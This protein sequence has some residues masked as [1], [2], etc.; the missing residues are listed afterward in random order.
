MK[1]QKGIIRD[2]RATF[3]PVEL[4]DGA[5]VW[6]DGGPAVVNRPFFRLGD[7]YTVYAPTQEE[8][9]RTHYRGP[10]GG[11]VHLPARSVELV[12]DFRDDI[13]PLPLSGETRSPS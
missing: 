7:P 1:W 11:T 9:Y 3:G 8:L 2:T 5:E 10:D 6:V 4:L 12:A 13:E